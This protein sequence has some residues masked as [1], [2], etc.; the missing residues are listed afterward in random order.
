MIKKA[1]ILGA[2]LGTRL[3]PLTTVR[4]KP[5]VPLFHRPMMQFALDRALDLGIQDIAIN[6]HHL[7]PVWEQ[8][9][10]TSVSETFTGLNGVSS[11][12]ATYNEAALALFQEDELLET[13]GGICNISEW[14][15][16]DDVL[17]YNGDIYCSIPLQPLIDLHSTG[18]FEATLILRSDGPATSIEIEGDKVIDIRNTHGKGEGT[19]QFTGIYCISPKI[20]KRLEPNKKESIIRA[21]LELA[22]E[23]KLGAVVVDEGEWF[24][25][26]T[27]EMYFE[28]HKSE[29]M[30]PENAEEIAPTAVVSEQAQVSNSWVSDGV[31][32]GDSA[33]VQDSV[34]WPGVKIGAGSVV[35]N[36]IVFTDVPAGETLEG[37]D[38]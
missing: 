4:P 35:K 24:D 21:F 12:S 34:V 20:L 22:A 31:Y 29:R 15:G 10:P 11:R 19:H 37:L 5:L 9:F 38:Y 1:F 17:V 32:I 33:D 23:G 28:A 6:T 16:K 30:R 26:G 2:G 7:A 3:R 8:F 25:L 36:S 14:I 18:E 27:R 13:G